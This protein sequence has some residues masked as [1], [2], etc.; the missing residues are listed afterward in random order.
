MK[1]LLIFSLIALWTTTGYGATLI[2]DNNVNAPTGAHV[3][4]TLQAAINAASS[5][6]TIYVAPSSQNYG[7]GTVVLKRLTILGIGFN[8]QKDIPH[9]SQVTTINLNGGTHGSRIS[10]LV[11]TSSIAV[12]DSLNGIYVDNCDVRSFSNSGHAS[13]DIVLKNN[14]FGSTITIYG[15]SATRPVTNVLVANNTFVRARLHAT[16]I[17]G[18][19]VMN[20]V[21]YANVPASGVGTTTAFSALEDCLVTNNIFFGMPIGSASGII[22]NVFNNNLIVFAAASGVVPANDFPTVNNNTESNNLKD[23]NP[24]FLNFPTLGSS[25][26]D[27]AFDLRLAEVSPAKNAGSDGTDIGIFGGQFPFH[28]IF[29]HG[30]PVSFISRLNTSGVVKVG[31]DLN[32][33]IE[34]RSAAF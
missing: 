6:D 17:V 33:Q 4:N 16:R 34:A 14:I 9:K 28:S 22:R 29:T 18:G 8:P 7:T 31:S 5:G 2:A 25:A 13:N 11:V 30:A 15:R 26:F 20:N 24:Q 27:F 32:V 1:F 3:Y 19:T 21:F 23:V 12:G 10:G